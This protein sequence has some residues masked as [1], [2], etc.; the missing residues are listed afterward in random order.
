MKKAI[1]IFLL[2]LGSFFG[3][4]EIQNS[5]K[6]YTEARTR[7]ITLVDAYEEYSEYGER[8]LKGIAVD[9]ILKHEFVVSLSYQH[10]NQFMQNRQPIPLQVKTTLQK[11]KYPTTPEFTIFM[12]IFLAILSVVVALCSIIGFVVSFIDYQDEK[13]RRQ[14]I[15]RSR[16][17]W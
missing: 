3:A 2:S 16:G 4:L 10:F 15:V 13:K 1:I 14:R 5:T 7:Q 8:Q 12:G 17:S 9:N 6:A 11:M